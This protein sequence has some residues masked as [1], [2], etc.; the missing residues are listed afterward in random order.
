M[1]VSVAT[2]TH[3]GEPEHAVWLAAKR[4][5]LDDGDREEEKAKER[6]ELG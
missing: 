2:A 1:P 3:L 6:R 5:R 4:L